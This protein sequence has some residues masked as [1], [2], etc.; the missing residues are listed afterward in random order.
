MPQPP[1]NY[2]IDPWRALVRHAVM[3]EE[4]ESGKRRPVLVRRRATAALEM[5]VI[6]DE[7]RAQYEYELTERAGRYMDSGFSDVEAD[8]LAIQ[9]LGCLEFWDFLNGAMYESEAQRTKVA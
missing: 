3:S 7:S 4:V 1:P 8:T 6:S 9:D 5:P 2:T